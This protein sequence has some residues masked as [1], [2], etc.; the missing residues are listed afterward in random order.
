MQEGKNINNCRDCKKTSKC[1]HHL[2]PDELDFISSKKK[3][4]CYEQGENL[5]KQDA[6]SPYVIYVVEG[7][8]KLHLQTGNSKKIN[9]KIAKTGDFLAFSSVFGDDCYNYSAVALKDSVVC[10]IDK[11]AL[12]K[13]MK[14]NSE[15]A[16]RIASRN[17]R[18]ENRL[19]ELLTD[20]NYKHMRGKLASA[21]LYLSSPEF[22]GFSVF[23]YLTR[24]DIAEFASISTESAIKF[25]KEFEKEGIVN[26][27]GK[28]VGIMDASRLEDIAQKG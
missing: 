2:Y 25:L 15:F 24:Q 11:Q 7:L 13:L 1:F 16:I 6:F 20:I 12:Y 8:V 4:L 19:L 23:Q 14:K 28:C 9:I 27:A 18:D 5:F 10:M 21:L 17:C 26:I 3:Q 22:D